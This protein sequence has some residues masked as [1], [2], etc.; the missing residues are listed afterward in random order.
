ML[1]SDLSF[2]K[3]DRAFSPRPDDDQYLRRCRR[4]EWVA[5]LALRHR[6]EL[7]NFRPPPPI[8]NTP[9]PHILDPSAAEN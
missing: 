1:S 7:F 9:T 8:P 4:L 5:P 3:M 2:V 6:G